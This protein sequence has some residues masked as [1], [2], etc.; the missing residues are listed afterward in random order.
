MARHSVQ[1]GVLQDHHGRGS[2]E[3]DRASEEIGGRF[4]GRSG[5]KVKMAPISE[6]KI[7][8]VGLGYVG[9]PL[10]AAFAGNG[11]D[12]VG[13]DRNR[14]RVEALSS[15]FDFTGAVDSA[16]LEVDNLTFTS[17]RSR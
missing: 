17:H 5:C 12:V 6:M 3:D 7:A 11:F 9:L 1:G 4:Y 15:R 10:A 16:A 13:F 2:D 8:V 14:E